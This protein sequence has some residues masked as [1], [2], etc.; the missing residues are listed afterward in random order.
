MFSL[1]AGFSTKAQS[2]IGNLH[3]LRRF[4]KR[5]TLE[6]NEKTAHP[7]HRF[8][9][10]LDGKTIKTPN[11]HILAVPTE[12]LA[13]LVVHEFERQEEYLKPALMPFL[14]LCRTA[15]DVDLTPNL[16]EQLLD[17]V[18]T[19]LPTDT[20]LFCADESSTYR[21]R[22]ESIT[23]PLLDKFSKHFGM[24]LYPSFDLQPP[25]MSEHSEK[26]HQMI[27]ELDNWNLIGLETITIWLKSTMAACLVME[28]LTTT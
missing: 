4:Y 27:V 12:R 23:L 25:K 16:R 15:V 7:K 22:Y 3:H 24:E 20:M 28:G 17:S 2:S 8:Q 13:L 26:F 19:F 6:L 11:R 5:A 18:Y 1:R 9:I 21:E 10:K 14:S